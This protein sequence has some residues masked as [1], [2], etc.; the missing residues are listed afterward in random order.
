M[1]LSRRVFGL[2]GKPSLIEF[3][4]GTVGL[5]Q[6]LVSRDG[7][8]VLSPGTAKSQNPLGSARMHDLVESLRE[9][10]DY[11]I[12][13][14]PPVG[15]VIDAKVAVQLVDK[16]LF[17]VRWQSTVRE[18]VLRMIESLGAERKLAGIALPIVDET[19]TP[20]YG[21]YSYHSGN[22]YGKYY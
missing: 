11:I 8:T 1:P 7:I 14:S 6:A 19:K 5:K 2:D 3:L 18:M 13:A 4:I 15:P 12:I 17:V 16:V 20:R 22:Y 21:R 9:N 10:C